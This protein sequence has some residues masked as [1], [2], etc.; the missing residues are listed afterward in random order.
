MWFTI[1]FAAM[2]ACGDD[3]GTATDAGGAPDAMTASDSGGGEDAGGGDDAGGDDVDSGGDATDAGSGTDAGDAPDAG[4][5]TDGGGGDPCTPSPC[6]NGGTCTVTAGAAA[7]DCPWAFAGATCATV[8]TVRVA[9]IDFPTFT[10]TPRYEDGAAGAVLGYDFS[11][12]GW[13]NIQGG[14]DGVGV[15]GGASDAT[16]EEPEQ[17]VIDFASPARSV[18]YFSRGVADGGGDGFVQHVFRMYTFGEFSTPIVD[19]ISMGGLGTLG[20]DAID[21]TT[22]I[23]RLTWD[24][25]GMDRSSLRSIYYE[26][27]DCGGP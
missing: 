22:E 19:L 14:A 18:S 9:D 8:C 26:W 1:P 10:S 13:V 4:R 17:V 16:Y 20:L 6:E 21:E 25:Y 23:G 2:A 27:A 11:V 24:G 5:T 3:G 12:A 7:C 15:V